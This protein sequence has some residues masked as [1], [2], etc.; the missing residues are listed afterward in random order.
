MPV[1][2]CKV[3]AHSEATSF[4]WTHENII[5]LNNSELGDLDQVLESVFDFIQSVNSIDIV[6]I[7]DEILRLD[8]VSGS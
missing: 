4:S 3:E 7:L 1:Q 2:P 8:F 5:S 6:F